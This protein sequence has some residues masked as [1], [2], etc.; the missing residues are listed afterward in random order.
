MTPSFQRAGIHRA[1]TLTCLCSL[2]HTQQPSQ[3][4]GLGREHEMVRRKLCSPYVMNFQAPGGCG[5]VPPASSSLRGA[6][7]HSGWKPGQQPALSSLLPSPRLAQYKVHP[8]SHTHPC[9][10]P[11]LERQVSFLFSYPSV[12]CHPL[13]L[14]NL[15]QDA[16]GRSQGL[17]AGQ[18]GS[19]GDQSTCPVTSPAWGTS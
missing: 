16:G 3:E 13:E 7:H 9:L 10:W 18:S 14:E 5:Q 17:G 1:H 4:K 11:G 15:E 12:H 6:A 8:S 2:T 19:N